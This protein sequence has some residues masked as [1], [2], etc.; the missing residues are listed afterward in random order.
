MLRDQDL[1]TRL[2]ELTELKNAYQSYKEEATRTKAELQATV[3]NLQ[4]TL[5]VSSNRDY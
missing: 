3:E 4:K 2:K 5:L 1:E